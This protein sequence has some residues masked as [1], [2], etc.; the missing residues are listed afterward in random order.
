MQITNKSAG[1]PDDLPCRRFPITRSLI[2]Q[3]Q[4][5]TASTKTTRLAGVGIPQVRAELEFKAEHT[6]L[7]RFGLGSTLAW[8]SLGIQSSPY[9]LSCPPC[10]HLSFRSLGPGRGERSGP[11]WINVRSRPVGDTTMMGNLF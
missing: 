2:G 1:Y 5:G 4:I 9:S 8:N 11:S 7:E 10:T 3:P 6:W